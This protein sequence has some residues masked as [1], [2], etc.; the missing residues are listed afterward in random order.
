MEIT[1]DIPENL[2][3]NLQTDK[4]ELTR[5]FELGLREF[6]ASSS[7]GYKSVA[8]VLEFFAN[9]K[10][11]IFHENNAK[12]ETTLVRT[13]W[14]ERISDKKLTGKQA[15]QILANNFPQFD[16]SMTRNGL[17]KIE[18]GWRKS[19]TIKPTEKCEYH[20]IWERAIITEEDSE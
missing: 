13:V 1:I 6:K 3:I 7:I 8:D 15:G 18:N 14:I 4:G 19:R 20:Y 9:V 5:I 16:N 2:A 12:G 17:I 11:Q 10:I